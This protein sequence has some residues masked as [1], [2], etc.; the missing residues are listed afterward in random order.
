MSRTI[1]IEGK[2]ITVEGCIVGQL[3]DNQFEFTFLLVEEKAIQFYRNPDKFKY[4]EHRLHERMNVITLII[5]RDRL[6][7]M[8]PGFAEFLTPEQFAHCAHYRLTKG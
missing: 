1:E 4:R 6:H 8:Q 5:N 2:P 7:A 3:G